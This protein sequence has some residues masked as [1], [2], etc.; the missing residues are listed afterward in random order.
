[1]D[2][3]I[4][5]INGQDATILMYRTQMGHIHG[6][7]LCVEKSGN[8]TSRQFKNGVEDGTRVELLTDGTVVTTYWK[9]GRCDKDKKPSIENKN[10]RTNEKFLEDL[11][12]KVLEYLD[13]SAL[14]AFIKAE[15][16]E[17]GALINF[18]PAR[19]N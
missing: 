19:H 2:G 13:R 9:D 5:E 1:M 17:G 6:S 15:E 14:W 8:I 18:G 16:P 7:H 3:R 4:C 10:P 11:G 12:L